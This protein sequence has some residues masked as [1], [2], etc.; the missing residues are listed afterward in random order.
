M[1]LASLDPRGPAA[2]DTAVLWWILLGFGG[3]V[4][5]LFLVVLL[6]ALRS[7]AS[8]SDGDSPDLIRRFLIGGGLALPVVVILMV[9]GLTVGAMMRFP[10]LGSSDRLVVELTGY[11][12]WWD[13]VYPQSGIRIA[14]E[15]HIPV[16]A[17]VEVRMRSADVVHSFW[18]P[19]LAGK[20][21]LLPDKQT[22]L[23]IEASEEG[24]YRGVCAE[25]C[26]LQHA[27]MAIT[28]VAVAP[29]EFEA[30]IR[31]TATGPPA[32]T[33]EAEVRGQTIFLETGCG[34]CHAIAGVAS[35]NRGPDLTHLA[36]RHTLAGGT[37]PNTIGHLRSWIADPETIKAGTEMEPAGLSEQ[38]LDDLIAYLATL[39]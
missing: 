12:W 23:V 6:R 31:Q 17:E 14:N 2:A 10:A 7:R 19:T 3:A 32:P 5:L 30:W 22:A 9:F 29:D 36:S 11:Q 15:M 39:E 20:I 8:E 28:V 16:G 38:D 26:G 18:V 37:V 25:F 24:S 13:V 35:G 21:D 4:F 33:G 34:E 27:K 1:E